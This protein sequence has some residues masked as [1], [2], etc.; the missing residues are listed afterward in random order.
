MRMRQRKSASLKNYAGS[1]AGFRHPKKSTALGSHFLRWSHARR[2]VETQELSQSV[3]CAASTEATDS[4]SRD[5]SSPAWVKNT[6]DD[7]W[8][9]QAAAG[10]RAFAICCRRRRGDLRTL[11]ELV[12]ET[13]E[14]CHAGTCSHHNLQRLVFQLQGKAIRLQEAH[15]L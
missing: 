13:A 4:T 6:L 7:S 3:R 2:V 1:C 12:P 8:Q 10:G 5:S 14:G 9:L 15:N 11:P